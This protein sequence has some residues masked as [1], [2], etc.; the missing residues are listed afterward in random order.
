MMSMLD[1]HRV[2]IRN[3]GTQWWDLKDV[4]G[5]RLLVF[6]LSFLSFFFLYPSTFNL[7]EVRKFLYSKFG[8][9]YFLVYQVAAVDKPEL[10]IWETGISRITRHPQFVGQ[11]LWCVAHTLYTG[12]SFMFA[13]SAVLCGESTSN[14]FLSILTSSF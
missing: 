6:V 2:L 5:M 14:D 4:P 7:L 3:E 13:T 12:T 11:L 1:T 10:H 8:S 9:I